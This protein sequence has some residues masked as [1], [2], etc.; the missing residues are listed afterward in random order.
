MAKYAY[1]I[2]GFS[3]L[4]IIDISNPASPII[5]GRVETPGYTD[6][7]YVKGNYAYVTNGS[8]GLQVINISNPASPAI[9]GSVKTPGS[10]RGVCVPEN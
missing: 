5:V 2:D 4:Q 10:A 3:G 7:V 6:G 1:V 9:V 8:F